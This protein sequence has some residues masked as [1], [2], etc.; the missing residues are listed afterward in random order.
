MRWS[1]RGQ[2]LDCYSVMAAQG[3]GYKIGHTVF[4]RRRTET[5]SGSDF[6]IAR[7]TTSS[8]PVAICHLIHWNGRCAPVFDG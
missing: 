4:M 6:D 5:Q 8:S 1:L 2:V 3:M 7:F